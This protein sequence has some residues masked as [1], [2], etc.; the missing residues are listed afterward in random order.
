[1]QYLVVEAGLRQN[2][3]RFF[4]HFYSDD[5]NDVKAEIFRRFCEGQ[6]ENDFFP[7]FFP[8]VQK[9]YFLNFSTSTSD[10]EKGT[11]YIFSPY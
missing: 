6:Y 9:K 4:R 1:M 10:A 5:F 2:R 11:V 7:P 8:C 3:K